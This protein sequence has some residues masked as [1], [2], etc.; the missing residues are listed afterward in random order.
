[1]QG[2]DLNSRLPVKFLMMENNLVK[3]QENEIFGMHAGIALALSSRIAR[4]ENMKN[5]EGIT[6]IIKSHLFL[7]ILLKI[8]LTFRNEIEVEPWNF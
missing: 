4:V 8:G 1:M 7:M 3:I 6:E 2:E 5:R